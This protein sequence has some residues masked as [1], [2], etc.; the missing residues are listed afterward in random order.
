M[1]SCKLC[2]YKEYCLSEQKSDNFVADNCEEQNAWK[3]DEEE[4]YMQQKQESLGLEQSL[5]ELRWQNYNT[6]YGDSIYVHCE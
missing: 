2:A 5:E 3:K 6:L 1:V 4:F